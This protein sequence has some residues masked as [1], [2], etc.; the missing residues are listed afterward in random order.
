MCIRLLLLP[1][2]LQMLKSM[3]ENARSENRDNFLVQ[4]LLS[5]FE[6]LLTVS[7]AGTP[8]TWTDRQGSWWQTGDI[9]GLAPPPVDAT[10][11]SAQF[12]PGSGCF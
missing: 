11:S 10:C 12:S 2:L 9:V 5:C 6:F 1:L 4:L 8:G 3:A 7:R